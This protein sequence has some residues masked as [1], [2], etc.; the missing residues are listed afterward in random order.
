MSWVTTHHHN[1]VWRRIAPSDCTKAF[2]II[3]S[4]VKRLT[5]KS[6]LRSMTVFR[7]GAQSNKGEGRETAR[8]LGRD[9]THYGSWSGA[10]RNCLT[11]LKLNIHTMPITR[12]LANWDC[13]CVCFF[14]FVCLF[15][16][17]FSALQYL[18]VFLGCITADLKLI[19][20]R[21]P[22]FCP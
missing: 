2:V 14:C 16:F 13:V 11:P 20:R 12:T 19:G 21:Q 5:A 9:K 8:R 7:L 15:F 18:P 10:T 1:A 6:S 22:S 4:Q 17:F 3:I